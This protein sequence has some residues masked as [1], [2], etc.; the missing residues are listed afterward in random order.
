MPKLLQLN[1]CLNFSTGKIT[2]S[3]GEAAMR[4]GWDSYIAYSSRESL[5]PCKS[6]VIKVGNKIG[7]V[8]PERRSE[9]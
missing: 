7:F 2:Q 8:S 9:L 4:N 6:K 5:V 3:I 1:E